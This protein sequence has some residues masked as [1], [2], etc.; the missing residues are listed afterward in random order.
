MRVWSGRGSLSV[1]HGFSALRI[2][3]GALETQKPPPFLAEEI[4]AICPG[5]N[6]L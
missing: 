1:R 5:M 3:G 6:F 4:A 2:R